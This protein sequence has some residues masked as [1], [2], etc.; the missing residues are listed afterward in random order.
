MH[1][2][3]AI[4]RRSLLKHSLAIGAVAALSPTHEILG[5]NDDLRVA[6]VGRGRELLSVDVTDAGYD[7]VDCYIGRE[8]RCEKWLPNG[9]ICCRRRYRGGR[10]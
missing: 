8:H 9:M 2:V 4:Q 5:V 3:R 10:R 1:R 6:V 7:G